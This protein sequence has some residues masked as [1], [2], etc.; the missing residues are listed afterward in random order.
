MFINFFPPSA[1]GGVYRPLSFVKYLSRLS[2][3]ITVIT[4]R[5]GG[6]WISDPA[7]MNEVPDSVRVIRTGSLSGQSVL[8]NLN[9]KS[10][11][12]RS[13]SRFGILRKLGEYFLVPDTYV[14]WIPFA[15]RAARALSGESFDIIYSTSPPDS[16]HLVAGR[17]ARRTRIPWVADFRD[18]W[19]GLHLRTPPTSF[20]RSIHHRMEARV[21]GADRVLVTTDWQKKI[22]EEKH[23][24]CNVVK[25]PNGFDEEDFSETMNG[26]NTGKGPDGSFRIVHCGMLTLGR[27]SGPFLDGLDRFLRSRPESR[28][29]V[30]VVFAGAR[31][32]NNEEAVDR[33]GL[34]DTVEFMD[35]LPHSE[36]V[37]LERGSHI[38]LLIKHDDDKYRGLIPG[39][40]FEYIGARRPILAIAPEGEAA[41]IIQKENRGEVVSHGSPGKVADILT[42]LYDLFLAGKL[43]E[44]Y[45]LNELASYS[46]REGAD[47]LDKVMRE[48]I[49]AAGKNQ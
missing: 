21:A 1:G 33:L 45:S 4:P 37:R 9:R 44:A 46:R 7:L 28:G 38:L 24:G 26:E 11:S 41:S 19:I 13:S 32:S 27:T 20:H 40:L 43:D 47:A 48:M 14:G 31:E 36:C 25:I 10:S 30:K 8:G 16:T 15:C 5:S 29:K 12:R 22:L 6:F 3:D 34:S 18:P 39:K 17:I 35:N 42:R 49:D 23:P 2:W